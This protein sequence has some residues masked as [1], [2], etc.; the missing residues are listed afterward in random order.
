M[1]SSID[2]CSYIFQNIFLFAV[3]SEAGKES[4]KLRVKARGEGG[5][6]SEK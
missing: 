4:S 6:F 2:Q 5:V 3:S 1:I